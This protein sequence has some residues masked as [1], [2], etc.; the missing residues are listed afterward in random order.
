MRSA[1]RGSTD[2]IAW[3]QEVFFSGTIALVLVTT[4]IFSSIYW[5]GY[6][7]SWMWGINRSLHRVRMAEFGMYLVFFSWS[8]A[9]FLCI[10]I[11]LRAISTVRPAIDFVRKV[12]GP[13]AISAPAIGFWIIWH[14]Q[15]ADFLFLNSPLCKW[16]P[17]EEG[18]AITC[19]LLYFLRWWPISKWTTLILLGL[20]A[21][22]WYRLYAITFTGGR[23]N[24]LVIPIAACAS[25]ATWGYD[26]RRNYS[27]TS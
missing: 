11:F 13:V 15:P 27:P 23:L 6:F 9:L 22:L 7:S 14:F 12:T 19:T 21:A 16:L 10:L 24:F 25:V 2:T 17:A 18:I 26:V 5:S 1:I 3:L 4:L 20:H 8:T